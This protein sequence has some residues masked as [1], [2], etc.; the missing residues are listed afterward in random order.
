M[1]AP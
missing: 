1:E